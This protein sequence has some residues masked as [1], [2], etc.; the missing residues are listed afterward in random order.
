MTVLIPCLAIMV[1]AS[2][3]I[4]VER[5]MVLNGV[6][7]TDWLYLAHVPEDLDRFHW[8][9]MYVDD[10][11][12]VTYGKPMPITFCK[13]RGHEPPYREGQTVWMK[14]RFWPDENCNELISTDGLRTGNIVN[15][16]ENTEAENAAIRS[17][18]R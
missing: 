17:R 11:V 3:A 13:D 4:P 2:V 15:E 7:K 10:E 9:T 5:A 6:K 18:G 14:Y 16:R 1:F 8:W 12:G